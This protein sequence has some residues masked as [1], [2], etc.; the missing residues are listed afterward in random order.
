[1]ERMCGERDDRRL[2]S[3]AGRV[4]ERGAGGGS[5]AGLVP[6]VHPTKSAATTTKNP[7]M[8][9]R[10]YPAQGGGGMGS[11]GGVEEISLS[12]PLRQVSYGCPHWISIAGPP[13]SVLLG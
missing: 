12:T 1:H 13:E 6:P 2:G 7:R 5:L 11:T 8:E 9:R 3:A 4:N 10:G